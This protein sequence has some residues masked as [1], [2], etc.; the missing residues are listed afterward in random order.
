ML[1]EFEEE[2]SKVIPGFR[3]KDEL[4]WIIKLLIDEFAVSMQDSSRVQVPDVG[5]F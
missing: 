1:R 4:F 3:V 5:T 2:R